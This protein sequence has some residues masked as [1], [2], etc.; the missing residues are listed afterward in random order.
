[1]KKQK[2]LWLGL[3]LIMLSQISVIA[4][5]RDYTPE[6][7]PGAEPAEGGYIKFSLINNSTYNIR[8]ES[9]TE[10][11]YTIGSTGLFDTEWIAPNGK[12]SEESTA[13]PTG[14]ARISYYRKGLDKKIH[15][16]ELPDKTTPT[17]IILNN[18]PLVKIEVKPV[19]MTYN[20][21]WG[22]FEYYKFYEYIITITDQ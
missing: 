22:G 14:T 21:F 17:P 16:F 2:I 13:A 8:F 11:T 6:K 1:M 15:K 18:G 7:P 4:E 9:E 12:K 10:S 5:K 19:Y 3:C 20:K